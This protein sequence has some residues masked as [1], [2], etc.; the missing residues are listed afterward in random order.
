MYQLIICSK[1]LSSG[2][3]GP[4]PLYWQQDLWLH[5]TLLLSVL[6]LLQ[7]CL[8]WAELLPSYQLMKLIYMGPS[9]LELSMEDSSRLEL[10]L[11]LRDPCYCS[12]SESLLRSMQLT[13]YSPKLI[14]KFSYQ[15][16]ELQC[17]KH[18]PL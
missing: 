5:T 15:S 16:L 10:Q 14:L 2:F 17:Q 12:T 6:P 7:H 9:M 18:L 1:H 11:Q 13:N 8:S 4:L 3:S